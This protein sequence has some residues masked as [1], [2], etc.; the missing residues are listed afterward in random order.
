V[1]NILYCN[2]FLFQAFEIFPKLATSLCSTGLVEQ[3]VSCCKALD[4]M[5]EQT[6]EKE[7]SFCSTR[8]SSFQSFPTAVTVKFNHATRVHLAMIQL[9]EKTSVI[10]LND[11]RRLLKPFCSPVSP[12]PKL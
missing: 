12:T 6:L 2:V 10:N 5:S 11:L 3:T 1:P 4:C 8:E 7:T 9:R